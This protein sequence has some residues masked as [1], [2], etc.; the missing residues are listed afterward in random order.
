MHRDVPARVDGLVA[1]ARRLCAL[2]ANPN[3]EYHWNWHPE[4]PRTALWGAICAVG[5]LPLAEVLLDAGANPTDGVSTH[6]A[7]GGGDLAALDLLHRFG[8]NVNG[9]PG[10]VPPLVYMMEWADDP[11]GPRWL[12][13][14]GAD[15]NLA[16]GVD[17]EAP[18]HVAARRWD[19]P[20]V[21]LLVQRG[22]DLSR[23]R[24]DG[25]TPHTRGGAV[26]QSRRSPAGCS[27]TA[28][29]DELS[30]LERFIACCARGDRAGA[31]AMLAARPSLAH[32]TAS[33]ASPHAASAGRERQRRA[34]SRPC[35]RA[36]SIQ[37]QGTRTT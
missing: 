20:M 9:I 31:D 17:G 8:V 11:A 32:R 28:R 35:S 24:A 21:E 33:G 25:C 5:H 15:P 36:A 10:G 7:G 27:P 2:G 16:W 1:I 29:Q 22:A 23:R 37:T 3:A 19:V 6:I 34:C 30:P 14:H 26:R 12:L 18:L 13:E 4:L